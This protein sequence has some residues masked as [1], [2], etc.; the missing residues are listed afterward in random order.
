MDE[1]LGFGSYLNVGGSDLRPQDLF[2]WSAA[3]VRNLM[4]SGSRY[5]S[6][7]GGGTNIVGFNQVN[8]PG[9]PGGS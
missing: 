6:I 3:G 2:S 8:R 9:F 7:N 4:S 1:V 5:V